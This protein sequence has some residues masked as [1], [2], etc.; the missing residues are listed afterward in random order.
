MKILSFDASTSI[1]GWAFGSD[2]PGLISGSIT[3]DKSQDLGGRLAFIFARVSMLIVELQPD[4][5]V[6]EEPFF[7]VNRGWGAKK[8]AARG[9]PQAGLIPRTADEMNEEEEAPQGGASFNPATIRA[10]QK[11]VGAIEIA[12]GRGYLQSEDGAR[13]WFPGVNLMEGESLVVVP[14]EFATPSQWRVTF[15]GYGRAPAADKSFDW[16]REAMKRAR[17]YGYSPRTADEAEAIGIAFHG[18][19]GKGAS[20]RKQA[21]LL[22]MVGGGL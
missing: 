7:P 10:L 21:S 20:A 8:P 9:R 19:F 16:K 22:D 1:T 14:I 2:H 11:V 6:I 13:P 4:L 5:I 15:F 17:H 12:A 3:P 18:L